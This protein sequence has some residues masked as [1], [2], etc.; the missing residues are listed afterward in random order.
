MCDTYLNTLFIHFSQFEFLILATNQ[1]GCRQRSK[2]KG[3]IKHANVKCA[4]RLNILGCTTM[5]FNEFSITNQ[6]ASSGL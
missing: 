6:R 3:N 5:N 1:R 2:K 4:L